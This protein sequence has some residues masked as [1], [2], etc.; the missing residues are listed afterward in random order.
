[1]NREEIIELVIDALNLIGCRHTYCPKG[2]ERVLDYV[3]LANPAGWCFNFFCGCVVTLH[4]QDAKGRAAVVRWD[5]TESNAELHLQV[6]MNMI[7]FSNRRK[8]A[9]GW[10]ELFVSLRYEYTDQAG[11]KPS[12]AELHVVGPSINEYTTDK[13]LVPAAR[14]LLL[15]DCPEEVFLDLLC[16][17]YDYINELRYATV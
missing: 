17:K 4:Y 6:A 2:K 11:R 8:L 7:E 9:V 5:F 1:M 3:V 10:N 16:E 14:A 13:D 12:Y 15:G